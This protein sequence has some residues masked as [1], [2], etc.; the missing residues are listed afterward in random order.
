M[1][2]GHG[3]VQR[4][5]LLELG[6]RPD[7]AHG[8]A[9]AVY[10]VPT[11]SSPTRAQVEAVRRALR[12]LRRQGLIGAVPRTPNGYPAREQDRARRNHAEEDRQLWRL[13]AELGWLLDTGSPPPGGGDEWPD[14]W[15]GG[16]GGPP[17]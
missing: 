6:Y 5:V 17:G 15:P 4:A 12:G 11:T 16:P 1:S 3:K 10:R 8:L 13:N 9:R 2:R 7:H 14:I